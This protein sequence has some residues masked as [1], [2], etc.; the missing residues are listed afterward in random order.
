MDMR[1]EQQNNILEAVQ[2][3]PN[4]ETDGR[5]AVVQAMQQS[6]AAYTEGERKNSFFVQDPTYLDP[7]REEKKS[8]IEEMEEASK[9]DATARKNQMAVLSHTTSPEDYE[10]MQ[11]EGF[12]LDSTASN[13]IVTVTDKIKAE[14]AKSGKDISC[15]GEGLSREELEAIAGSAALATQLEH[16]L[17]QADLPVTEENANAVVDALQQ[18][19]AMGPLTEGA[20]KYILENELEPTIEN[21]YKA[22]YSGRGYAPVQNTQANVYSFA[23]QVEKIINDA[24]L[25]VNNQTMAECQWLLSNQLPITEENLVYLEELN[26]LTLPVDAEKVMEQIVA[27]ISEGNAPTDAILIDSH[28]LMAKAEHAVE[29]VTK[30]TEEDLAYIVN[31]GMALTVENLEEAA[32][33]RGKDSDVSEKTVRKENA[34]RNGNVVSEKAGRRDNVASGNTV[35]NENVA[36]AVQAASKTTTNT[37][38]NDIVSE[39]NS[40]AAAEEAES[41]INSTTTVEDTVNYT[42]KALDMLTA[43]RQLAEVR[44][45]MTAE[46]NYSLL[47]R[48][49]SIDTEPLVQLVEELKNVENQYY[50]NLL[51]AQGVEASEANVSMFMETTVKLQEMQNVPAYVLGIPNAD[52]STI[53]KVHESGMA[54]KAALEK[55]NESYETLRVQPSAELGDSIQK[56]FQNVDEILKDLGLD[57]TEANQRAVRILGYNGLEITEEAVTAMK[58]ADKEV[59]RVFANLT[60][61]V[62]TEMIKKGINPLE[63]DFTTL[64]NISAEIKEEVGADK[65]EKFSEYLWKLEKNH[66]ITERERSSYIGIYRLIHQVTQTDGAAVGA[67]VNQGAELTLK[68]LLTAVRSSHK[69]SKMDVKVSDDFGAIENITQKSASIT[70]QIMTAYQMNCIYDAQD[71]MTPGKL[72]ALLK[73]HPNWQNMTPEQFAE[74]LANIPNDEVEINQQYVKEQL[75]MLGQC[76][77]SSEEIYQILQQYDIPNTPM[78]I[79]ALESMMSDRNRLFRQIF[80]NGKKDAVTEEDIEDIKKELIKEFGEAVSEPRELAEAQET[81]GKIA[82]NVMKT[83][84]ESDEVTSVDIR[85]MRLMQAQ[86]SMNSLFAK[87]EKY[88]VPVIA[89]GEVTNVSLKIVRGVD[90]KGIVDIMLESQVTGKIA[91]TFQAKEE[92]ISGLVA[93]DKEE[94]REW[95]AQNME[96]LRTLLQPNEQENAELRIA[97]VEDLDLNHFSGS[98]VSKNMKSAASQAE[99]AKSM[100]DKENEETYHVQ[101][102][103]LYHMAESFIRFIK[104]L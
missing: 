81:L 69:T 12:S 13:T 30:A 49:I 47:K 41:E 71:S 8:V 14:L 65:N 92:G 79:A 15:F 1:I 97:Y 59:Q 26:D 10:K 75:S 34:D 72:H 11:E 21:I 40:I 37:V 100:Q 96:Q 52:V 23:D 76:A 20:K 90:T 18:A 63:M 61:A 29:V 102:T 25:P 6:A 70:D 89:G 51:Q 44:L 28:T 60:P 56:A 95:F 98:V 57:L 48:G 27:A 5:T 62:V 66:E 86:L 77:N 88:S 80:G 39:T 9:M 87:D 45:A 32:K 91:A 22:E 67:L 42:Q 50:A 3:N 54:L 35:T 99:A 2:T 64:N 83:M 84:V 94:M 17:Q 104:E 36:G 7:T 19:E 103:R 85:E 58:A 55:A 73:R 38:A 93:T 74:T 4:R 16:A 78:N 24:G 33:V 53:N 43:Q 101:T 31:T 68:N 82:E 46:A